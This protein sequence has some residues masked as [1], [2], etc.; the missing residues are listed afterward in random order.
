MSVR[1]LRDFS[2]VCSAV[3]ALAAP[4]AGASLATHPTLTFFSS[5]TEE[6]LARLEAEAIS[7]RYTRHGPFQMPAPGLEI[8]APSLVLHN[9]PCTA[10]D[11]TRLLTE[12]AAWRKLPGA[13]DF[14]LTLPDGRSFVF[15]RSPSLGRSSLGGFVRRLTTASTPENETN[16]SWLLRIVHDGATGLRVDFRP[17]GVAGATPQI[18]ELGEAPVPPPDTAT[19]EPSLQ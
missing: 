6:P 9:Q 2:Q 18:A 15:V 11:W 19:P 12:L 3:W 1:R 16:A 10:E 7:P 5:I 17:L 4:L 14:L 13:S 8:E